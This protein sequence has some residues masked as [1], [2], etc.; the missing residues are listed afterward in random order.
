MDEE[1]L[2]RNEYLAAE[3]RI[4]MDQLQGRLRLTDPQRITLA[5]Y[6]LGR[7][8]LADAANF[9]KPET[10]LGWYRRLVAQKF[11][12]SKVRGI[13]RAPISPGVETLV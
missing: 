7:K 2:L 3:N 13:G 11:D 6:R 12:G 1:L 10:I 9:V 5:G 4:L 8:A